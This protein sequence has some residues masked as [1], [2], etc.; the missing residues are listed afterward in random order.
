M[1]SGCR[2]QWYEM[3]PGVSK[4]IGADVSLRLSTPV[5]H[6]KSSAVAVWAKPGGPPGGGLG[7]TSSLRQTT[8]VP[9]G[10]LMTGG[11]NWKSSITTRHVSAVVGEPVGETATVAVG[12]PYDSAGGEAGGDASRAAIIAALGVATS[13]ASPAGHGFTSCS[14]A[15]VCDAAEMSV[16]TV[17]N[18]TNNRNIGLLLSTDVVQTCQPVDRSLGRRA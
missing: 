14:W 1:I 7:L 5:F 10:I 12:E 8:A 11:M 13:D 18:A 16:R 3:L 6:E 15:A 4:T 17:T 9:T 2:S